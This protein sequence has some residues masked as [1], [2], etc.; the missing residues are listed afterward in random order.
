MLPIGFNQC[1][2]VVEQVDTQDLKS[3]GLTAVPVR[4]RSGVR[5][6]PGGLL[7]EIVRRHKKGPISIQ[8]GGALSFMVQKGIAK[9]PHF[10][11]IRWGLTLYGTK[12]NGA[13][14]PFRFNS[15]G[16]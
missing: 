7:S 8:F 1:A 5:Q 16:P 15:V 2:P 4:F 13:I 6:K 12:A 10:D 14:A 9:E 11:L 3:C